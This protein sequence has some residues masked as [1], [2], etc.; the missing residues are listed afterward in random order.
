MVISIL[1][2]IALGIL[3]AMV[4]WFLFGYSPEIS[5]PDDGKITNTS[6]VMI[7]MERYILITGQ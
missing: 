2:K 4:L 5:T 6:G 7:P 3:V 1:K